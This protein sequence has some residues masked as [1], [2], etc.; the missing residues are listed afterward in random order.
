[1]TMKY[2][3]REYLGAS[4]S[5][6][7]YTHPTAW[8]EALPYR[9]ETKNLARKFLQHGHF[10]NSYS[11]ARL[12]SISVFAEDAGVSTRTVDRFFTKMVKDGYLRPALGTALND[13]FPRDLTYL[14]N[15]SVPPPAHHLGRSPV[16]RASVDAFEADVSGW[17]GADL[18]R[19]YSWQNSSPSP[20]PWVVVRDEAVADTLAAPGI[21]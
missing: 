1:M 14:Y 19:D 21:K 9:S 5:D 3:L 16:E 13:L 2:Q 7:S 11:Q 17:A 15:L 18:E 4:A 8:I 10:N 6:A 12:L 20:P